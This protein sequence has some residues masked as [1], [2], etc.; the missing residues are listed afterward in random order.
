MDQTKGNKS[1]LDLFTDSIVKY[2]FRCYACIIIG[3]CCNI[4]QCA[5]RSWAAAELFVMLQ[6]YGIML[7]NREFWRSWVIPLLQV[8]PH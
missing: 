6:C 2:L 7:C 5:G 8:E 4:S 3:G 1:L